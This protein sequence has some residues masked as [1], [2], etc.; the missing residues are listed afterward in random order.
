M[1]QKPQVTVIGSFNT[2]LVVRTPRMPAKGETILG[3]TY[4]TGPGGKGANQ[5][6]AAARLGAIVTMV[7]RLGKDDFGDRAEENLRRE[8]IQ[9][10]A[11]LRTEKTHTG[12]AFIIVDDAGDNTIVVAPGAN[13]ALSPADVDAARRTIAQADILLLDL[14]VPMETI[15]RAAALAQELNVR[16]IL[17]PAPG[18]PL[19]TELLR[20]VDVLTPNET[21]AQII[22]GLPVSNLE[23]AHTAGSHLLAQGVGAVVITLG[24]LGALSVTP[25]GAQH[26][27]AWQV[28]VVDTTGAGDAFNGALAV[29]L[30][31]GHPLPQAVTFANA[32]AALQVT[33]MGTASAMPLRADVEAFLQTRPAHH[34]LEVMQGETLV[35]HSDG[36]WLYP[37]LDLEHFLAERSAAFMPY[38]PGSLTL[39]DKIIG[40]AAALLIVRLGIRRVHAGILSELGAEVLR[41]FEVNYDYEHLVP[42]IAC[43]TEVL[44]DGEFDPDKAHALIL[45]RTRH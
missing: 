31:E 34:A 16:V 21:E 4:F 20:R 38:D 10:D 5:A 32:T 13:E 8:G 27:P 7:A 44:L 3:G 39:R 2:D 29:A 11:V 43:Q 6:V 9:T 19:S 22:T 17:N 25:Q 40:R 15:E 33:K 28:Q 30:A 42:Q 36:K 41:H 26:I 35:F 24:T 14:E 37:L 45:E 23:E 12:V 1:I 18:R